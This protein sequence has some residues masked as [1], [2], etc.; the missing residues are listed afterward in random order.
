MSPLIDRPEASHKEQQ[1]TVV[2][3]PNRLQQE[4][5]MICVCPNWRFSLRFISSTSF[6][7][8][9]QQ[10]QC[11][12]FQKTPQWSC[13]FSYPLHHHHFSMMCNKVTKWSY[14]LKLLKW[15][16]FFSPHCSLCVK[17]MIEVA[18]DGLCHTM[19]RVICQII[20]S[21]EPNSSNPVMRSTLVGRITRSNA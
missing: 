17:L 7:S 6:T 11:S 10:D 8:T 9:F 14:H 19:I 13:S 18:V 16:L 1:V 12:S 3:E 20:N 4:R 2:M 15:F 5:E 21:F